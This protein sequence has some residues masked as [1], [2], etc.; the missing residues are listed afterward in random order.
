MKRIKCPD[1]LYP[2]FEITEWGYNFT[3]VP[4]DR[5]KELIPKVEFILKRLKKLAK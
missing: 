5:I 2:S 1:G 4:K 3:G